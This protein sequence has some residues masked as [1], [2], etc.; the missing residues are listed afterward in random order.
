MFS[1]E[2]F[3]VAFGRAAGL[4][5]DN[6][7]LN[8]ANRKKVR[9]QIMSSGPAEITDYL[10]VLWDNGNVPGVPPF[11]QTLLPNRTDLSDAVLDNDS[12]KGP[13]AWHHLIY[14]FLVEN[15]RLYELVGL[16]IRSFAEGESLGVASS[17]SQRWLGTT[18]ALFYRQQA[19]HDHTSF[20]TLTSDSRSDG[21]SIRRNAYFRMFGMEL[22]HGTDNNQPY[23]YTRPKLANS[24]FVTT[25]EALLRELW[26]AIINQGTTSTD[27]TDD[28]AVIDHT[29]QLR[30]MLN[31]RRINGTLSRE[32]FSAVATLDWLRLAVS[33]NS[34]I[35]L[36]L[37]SEAASEAERI[38]KV[39]EQVG[40]PASSKSD[41]YLS[42][43]VPATVFLRSIELG[44]YTDV[45]SYITLPASRKVVNDIITHWSSATGKVMKLRTQ[46][47]VN[48]SAA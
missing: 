14:A 9:L 16:V 44:I 46:P 11:P 18:E 40:L 6:E 33:F 4:I 23:P 12:A 21:R 43:A 7:I 41:D 22:N 38:F 31:N 27:L 29:R 26:I 35:L 20:T 24:E 34:P 3:L 25:F 17:V 8:E 36:D 1:N 45:A 30:V 19:A 13:S 47:V 15:T 42:L 5:R 48:S 2:Q 37:R 39:A 28:G 32:E 10:Q